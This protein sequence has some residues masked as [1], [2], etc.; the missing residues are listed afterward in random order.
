MALYKI[1][2]NAVI[3]TFIDGGLV[4]IVPERCLV[5]LN[6]SAVEIVNLLDG[7][8]TPERVASEIANTHDLSHD[9]QITN[10]LQDVLEL[11]DKLEKSG[12]LEIQSGP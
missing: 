3:E 6:P 8:R 2:K 5:E 9:Y 1:S 7:Q 10:I 4:L 12:V 11:C